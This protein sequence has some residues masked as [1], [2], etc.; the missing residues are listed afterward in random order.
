MNDTTSKTSTAIFLHGIMELFR[1]D[2]PQSVLDKA[3]LS[4][5]DYI[6]VT[7]AGATVMRDKIERYVQQEQLEPGEIKAIGMD[8]GMNLK[9]AVFFNG[10]NGHALD[11]DDGTNT[12]IIHLGS[13]IFS[14]LLPLAQ[15]YK[16]DSTKFLEAAV[17]GYETSFT[18]AASIQPTHKE[19]G[20]H[21]TGTCGVLGIS[22]A[23]AYM[24]DFT[25]E[26]AQNAFSIACVS[27][28]GMLSV[29][30]DHS[31]L[32]PY[33]V[34]KSALLGL[35]SIQMARMGFLGHSDPLG[36]G[37]GYLKMMTGEALV[38]FKQPHLNGTY[39]IEK[40]YTKLYAACRYCHPAIEAA[41]T[42]R[43]KYRI[44]AS[45]V[46]AIHVKTYYW[47][48]NKHDH[49]D[50]SGVS[51][52]KM[53]IPYGIAVGLIYGKA[54]LS[55]YTMEQVKNR[56]IL[57]LTSKV[58]V[59]SDDELTA[60][61]PAVTAAVLML[62]TKSGQEFMERV[63]FPK[64]EPENPMTEKEFTERFIELAVYGGKKREESAEML[65]FIKKM[66]GCM[67]RLYQYL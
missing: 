9:D 6:G 35:I 54:G 30:D 51:S 56:T 22:L 39:A 55:E 31:E 50:I 5:A 58:S 3:R 14:V 48:V 20:Y 60:Q 63:D 53:S 27:A 41:I 67:D 40:T 21:A 45:E 47:A 61:F 29:L 38:D 23:V 33:N 66:D 52:A 11:F 18:M 65:E 49:T 44:I 7:L 16:V 64:G 26:Q 12:G 62:T 2:I 17:I 4:L 1:K 43:E 8:Q 19:L 25:E 28:T 46:S 36:G 34:A 15:K 59:E 42:L 32:K 24:L 57:D 13:P 10:L 37:R